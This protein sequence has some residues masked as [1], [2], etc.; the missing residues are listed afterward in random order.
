MGCCPCSAWFSFC[1]TS[2]LEV[3]DWTFSVKPLM[4]ARASCNCWSREAI[5]GEDG[6]EEGVEMSEN[7][8][9]VCR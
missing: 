6:G 1:K 5:G 2:R 8:G 3:N 7:V 9:E 4:A